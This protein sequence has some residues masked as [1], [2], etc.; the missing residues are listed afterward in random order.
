MR[1]RRNLVWVCLVALLPAC[2]TIP[3]EAPELSQQLGNRISAVHKA[4]Q[5][6][7][8]QYFDEKRKK[9][10][11]FVENVYVPQF[12]KNFFAEPGIQATWDEVVRSDDPND[13]LQF[14]TRVGPKLQAFIN[15]KRLEFI[16]PLDDLERTVDDQLKADYDT[17]AAINNTLTSFLYSAA[18]VDANRKR[19]LEMVGIK[20]EKIQ[21][22]IDKTDTAVKELTAGAEKAAQVDARAQQFKDKVKDIIS[23]VKK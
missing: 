17:M 14:I 1:N 22:V 10:D 13:R 19:Y 3:P 23:K 15:K 12:A 6:L 7:L 11:E 2:A 20:D 18:K 8:K 21:E 5:A 4:H 9:V 16:Q